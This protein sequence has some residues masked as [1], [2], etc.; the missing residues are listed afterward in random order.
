MQLKKDAIK[1]SSKYLHNEI[2]YGKEIIQ[3]DTTKRLNFALV[4]IGEKV[5]PLFEIMFWNAGKGWIFEYHYKLDELSFGKYKQYQL[6]Y[7]E[8]HLNSKHIDLYNKIRKLTNIPILYVTTKSFIL[9]PRLKD[10][11]IQEHVQS[12][13]V[14]QE[15]ELFLNKAKQTIELK[16]DDKIKLQRNG[17]DKNSFKN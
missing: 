3:S 8:E 10:F 7:C 14:I 16:V 12:H 4:I 5:I 2:S 6:K 15:L 11:N 13:E 17:F 9:N 1:I